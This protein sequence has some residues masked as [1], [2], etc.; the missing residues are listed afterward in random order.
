MTALLILAQVWVTIDPGQVT[1]TAP[2]PPVVLKSP[3]KTTQEGGDRR[4]DLAAVRF[5]FRLDNRGLLGLAKHGQRA[6]GL[7]RSW[8]ANGQMVAEARQWRY[9]DATQDAWVLQRPPPIREYNTARQR[10]NWSFPGPRSRVN[11]INHLMGRTGDPQHGGKFSEAVLRTLS[12]TELENLHS[13]D[14]EGRPY[15]TPALCPT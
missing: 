2:P 3:P 13:N 10:R 14:H 4:P 6:R 7:F 8:S 9:F 1:I 11:L 12:F 15:V 5:T